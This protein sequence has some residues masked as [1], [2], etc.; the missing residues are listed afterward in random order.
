MEIY[1]SGRVHLLV[2]ATDSG[3]HDGLV[4]EGP[5]G[6]DY[7]WND[8]FTAYKCNQHRWIPGSDA[9]YAAYQAGDYSGEEEEEG[10]YE[11]ADVK[12][13]SRVE[14]FSAT[15]NDEICF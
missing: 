3:E 10:S 14:I 6:C 7:S 5:F 1:G 12:G 15:A 11:D 13:H 8:D 4:V 9:S 2:V